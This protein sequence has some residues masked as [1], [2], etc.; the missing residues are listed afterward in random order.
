M[1]TNGCQPFFGKKQETMKKKHENFEKFQIP[2]FI[3]RKMWYNRENYAE[4]MGGERLL[5]PKWMLLCFLVFVLSA[6]FVLGVSAEFSKVEVED[7][8]FFCQSFSSQNSTLSVD[9]MGRLNIN[10]KRES[11]VVSINFDSPVVDKEHNAIRLTMENNSA[12]NSFILMFQ[13][14]DARG[15]EQITYEKL[16]IGARNA[17]VDY[18]VYIDKRVESILNLSLLFSGPVS[19]TVYLSR[20][21]P[22]SIYDSTEDDCGVIS[23]CVYDAERDCVEISG[24]IDYEIVTANRNAKLVLYAVD[25]NAKTLP[26][27]SLALQSVPMSSHFDFSLSGLSVDERLQ[28]F[29]VAVVSSGGKILY[30]F[31]PR[32]PT[33]KFDLETQEGFIKGVSSDFGVLSAK[34]NVKLA[35]IEVDLAKMTTS[36]GDGYLYAAGGRYH[37][38]DR[39]YVSWLDANVKK[40]YENGM[41]IALRLVSS[42]RSDTGLSQL[43]VASEE[44]CLGL[45][46]YTAFLCSRYDS[47]S[48]G[49][50]SKIIVGD[51]IDENVPEHVSAAQYAHLYVNSLVAIHEGAASVGREIRLL[52]PISDALDLGRSENAHASPRLLLD[53]IGRVLE[54]RCVGCIRVTVMLESDAVSNTNGVEKTSGFENIWDFTSFLKH[55][56]AQYSTIFDR[57]LYYW[58]PSAEVNDE[59]LKASLLHGY[60]TLACEKSCYGFILSTDSLCRLSLVSEMLEN[61]RSVDTVLGQSNDDAALA[62]LGKTDWNELILGYAEEKVHTTKCRETLDAMVAPFGIL[63]S[64]FL[65]DFSDMGNSYGW[66]AGDGCRTVVMERHEETN[67]ALAAHMTPLHENDYHSELVYRFEE[68]RLLPS[69]DA[70]SF[71]IRIDGPNE[72]YRV[73]I[74]LSNETEISQTEATLASGRLCSLYVNSAELFASEG[75]QCVRIFVIPTSDSTEEYTL[76]IGSISAHSTTQDSKQLESLLSANS[77]TAEEESDDKVKQPVWIYVGV[78]FAVVGVIIIMMLRFRNDEES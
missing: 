63:G 67:R 34:A 24:T 62:V 30:S 51:C 37:Y 53:S 70:V 78:F 29:I 4:S 76:L 17:C 56:S 23:S 40:H 59:L 1:K 19:G 22:V 48:R 77:D 44:E 20:I 14:R 65:W 36:V 16:S 42:R 8:R 6:F 52:V 66:S 11:P 25:L 15:R 57:Y 74:Q 3:M 27:G 55:I 31:S 7:E 9:E 54:K 10:F 60:Y 50:V 75:V 61:F 69:V 72:D 39:Q 64:C 18:Y 12:C 28:A 46:A 33:T 47:G 38:F 58:E 26:Y 2:L 73:V 71:D 5:K 45:Y 32:I 49:V 35:V 21:D 13:Y 68:N 43:L 41:E